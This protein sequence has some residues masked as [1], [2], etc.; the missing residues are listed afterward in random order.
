MVRYFREG[1]EHEKSVSVYSSYYKCMRGERKKRLGYSF[2]HILSLAMMAACFYGVY[3][4]VTGADS[5]L[6]GAGLGGLIL[7]W[8]GIVICAAM[9]VLFF[10]QGFVA[11]IVTFVT[12]LIGL[13]K[14][15]E[16]AAN[17]AAA[18]VALLSVIALIAA[19]VLL[20]A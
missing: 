3:F 20:F 14:A 10:L 7:S 11:Q 8:I 18:L 9:G 6:A 15:E 19:G 5:V 13:G 2:L 4:M 16:R 1:G 17:L 12:G